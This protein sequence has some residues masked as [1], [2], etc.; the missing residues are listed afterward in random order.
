MHELEVGCFAATT[1]GGR[2]VSDQ[3]LIGFDARVSGGVR[4]WGKL[5]RRDFLL[6]EDVSRPLSAGGQTAWCSIFDMGSGEGI[7]TPEWIGANGLWESLPRMCG[8]LDDGADGLA[9]TVVA[10]SWFSRLG[11][12]DIREVISEPGITLGPY[13]EPTEPAFPQPGWEWLGFDVA[14]GSLLSGLTECGYEEDEDI[15]GDRK[16]WSGKLNRHHLFNEEDAAFDFVELVS[17][18]VP[19]HAPFFVFGL[20]RVGDGCP[21]PPITQ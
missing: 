20:Y 10:V 7:T 6:R 15:E 5:R 14:D 2:I 11:F 16:S 19:E 12:Q 9:Y 8:Y 18:R 21:P 17:A 13:L 1:F 4:E 3:A